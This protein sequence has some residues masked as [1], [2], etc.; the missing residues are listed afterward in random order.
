LMKIEVIWDE[1]FKRIYR[2]KIKKRP[3]LKSSFWKKLELFVE[4]PFH[5]SLRT[6]KLSGRLNDLWA[7]TID[8]E[9]RLVFEFIDE[10]HIVL[11][12]FG[13]HDEVY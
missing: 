7:I 10:E 1:P 4:D 12:D 6:H 3:D 2:K 8:Y 11:V 9:V 5:S 13:G